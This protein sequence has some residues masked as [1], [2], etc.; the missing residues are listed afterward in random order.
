MFHRHNPYL[1]RAKIPADAEDPK[2]HYYN[3]SKSQN[4]YTRVLCV[5]CTTRCPE[6][7]H[8]IHL[9]DAVTLRGRNCVLTQS[10]Q[11]YKR[12]ALF[13]PK[14]S[15][16]ITAKETFIGENSRKDEA[17]NPRTTVASGPG[18]VIPEGHGPAVIPPSPWQ[19]AGGRGRR[20]GVTSPGSPPRRR[21][22]ESSRPR[23]RYRPAANSGGSGERGRGRGRAG[24]RER[25]GR[26]EAGIGGLRRGRADPGAQH[27]PAD[28]VSLAHT[29]NRPPAR[30]LGEDEASR[31]AAS[32]S[33]G[34][35]GQATGSSVA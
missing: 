4:V 32:L 11:S 23:G 5:T 33:L 34:A 1:F 9:R 21:R 13:P 2:Q 3:A 18:P 22:A 6:A 7:I 8:R 10:Q 29:R 30:C 17:R 16:R 19:H 35:A 25:P 20:A 26:E 24:R 12:L 14:R 15:T 28:A 31:P 27:S